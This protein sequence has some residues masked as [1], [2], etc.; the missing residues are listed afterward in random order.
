MHENVA[1]SD[2]IYIDLPS[3]SDNGVPISV[4]S[5]NMTAILFGY[6]GKGGWVLRAIILG[7]FQFFIVS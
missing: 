6:F 2:S 1:C 4:R 7:A 5:S 3:H